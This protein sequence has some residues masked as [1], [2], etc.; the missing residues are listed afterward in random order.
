MRRGAVTS[1]GRPVATTPE[2]SIPLCPGEK[3]PCQP[4]GFRFLASRATRQDTAAPGDPR[5]SFLFFSFFLFFVHTQCTCKFR[6]QRSNLHHGSNPSHCSDITRS[7]TCCATRELPV[8]E[9]CIQP[10]VVV[11][12]LSSSWHEALT[13]SGRLRARRHLSSSLALSR[14]PCC[15]HVGLAPRT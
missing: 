7:L 12:L 10:A 4:F 11:D 1:Q 14:L 9:L 15:T 6:G 13:P 2:E 3:P 5:W 8:R